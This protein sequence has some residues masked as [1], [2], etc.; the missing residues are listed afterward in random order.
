M[1]EPFD[2]LDQIVGEKLS[3]ITFVM[4]YYQFQFD[5]PMFNVLTPVSVASAAGGAVSGDD[6]FRNLVCGQIAKVVRSV[7]VQEGDA[8]AVAFEDGSEIRFSLK[9]ED[10]SGPEGVIF[11]GNADVWAV[12]CIDKLVTPEV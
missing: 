1:P 9:Q 2:F 3:A 4:D 5:G 11:Y 8:I 6:Q 10:Y 12:F 7:S